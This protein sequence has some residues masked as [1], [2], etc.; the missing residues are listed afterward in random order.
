[1]FRKPSTPPPE[2]DDSWRGIGFHVRQDGA[3]WMDSDIHDN[4][5][6]MYHKASYPGGMGGGCGGGG[7]SRDSWRGIGFHVRQD[8]AF[9]M[10]SD[11]HDND[12]I[13]YHKASYL[14]VGD[15]GPA[16][17]GTDMVRTKGLIHC[18]L[19]TWFDEALFYQ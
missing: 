3:F 1:M 18:F 11:I 10:D 16:L 13:M 15:G 4:D 9:W 2:Y 6:I 14:V 7:G 12:V 17:G 8:G 19:S 5:V